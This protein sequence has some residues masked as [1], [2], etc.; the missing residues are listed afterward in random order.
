M[1]GKTLPDESSL[2]ECGVR[3][4]ATT[5]QLICVF[6]TQ[7]MTSS[8][9]QRNQH[10]AAAGSGIVGL[11]FMVTVK[12]IWPAGRC[13]RIGVTVDTQIRTLKEQVA[14]CSGIQVEK[15]MLMHR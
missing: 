12:E 2:I 4:E 15:Q 14:I 9:L 10:L 11:E 5:L 3:N 13:H 8:A 1:G 7:Y 6:G